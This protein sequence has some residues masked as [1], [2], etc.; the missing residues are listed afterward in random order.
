MLTLLF[1]C[2]ML[3]VFGKLAWVAIKMT[4][5]ITKVL[6]GIVFLPI[7]LIILFV[8]GLVSLAFPILVILGVIALLTPAKTV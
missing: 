4:W 5:G 2:L 6:F 1:I 3:S 8:S 7:T